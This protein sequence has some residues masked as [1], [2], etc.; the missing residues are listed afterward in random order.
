MCPLSMRRVK[1]QQTDAS[2]CLCMGVWVCMCR[3]SFRSSD[4]VHLREGQGACF[5][6]YHGY[7]TQTRLPGWRS[8]TRR[9]REGTTSARLI[10]PENPHKVARYPN[11]THSVSVPWRAERSRERTQL[12]NLSWNIKKE[13]SLLYSSHYSREITLAYLDCVIY[14]WF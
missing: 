3:G 5:Q 6:R 7:G 4:K 2:V 13:L 12:L 8:P 11:T 10:M 9:G 14:T 1:C